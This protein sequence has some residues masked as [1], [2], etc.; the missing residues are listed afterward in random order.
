MYVLKLRASFSDVYILLGQLVC[1]RK[2][3]LRLT[4]QIDFHF[5]PTA[6]CA[7]MNI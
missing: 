4:K 7:V 6:E 2:L 1:F 3:V 5:V